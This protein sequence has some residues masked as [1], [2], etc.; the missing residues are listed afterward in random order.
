MSLV[1]G[2]AHDQHFQLGILALK[3]KINVPDLLL[4]YLF[5]QALAYPG[6]LKQK[7][8]LSPGLSTILT[9]FPLQSH[10]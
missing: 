8:L 6:K 7:Q 5:L 4:T 10:L 3:K 9:Y 2:L 1:S